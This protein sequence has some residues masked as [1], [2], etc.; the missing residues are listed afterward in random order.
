MEIIHTSAIE[1]KYIIVMMTLRGGT[2]GACD[3]MMDIYA[4]D[5]ERTLYARN[6]I[7]HANR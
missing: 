1:M 2:A 6:Y 4:C 7:R 5:G 3:G